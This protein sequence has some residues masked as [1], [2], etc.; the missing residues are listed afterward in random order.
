MR[1]MAVHNRANT[2]EMLAKSKHGAQAVEAARDAALQAGLGNHFLNQPDPYEAV[3]E[4]HRGQQAAREIGD[5]AAYKEKLKQEILAE[6]AK[7]VAAA[8]ARPG[9]PQVLPPSLS[10]ATRASTVAPVITDPNDF[11]KSMFA[12]PSQTRT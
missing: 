1:E 3:M 6:L 4:W 11:F 2:S 8:P 10:S 5:P 9:Q 7:G 12:R